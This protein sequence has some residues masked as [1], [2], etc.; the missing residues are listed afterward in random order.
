MFLSDMT[1]PK[2]RDLDRG[3]P[4]VIPIA[5]VESISAGRA[6]QLVVARAA[7][8][9]VITAIAVNLV[10]SVAPEDNIVAQLPCE[11]IIARGA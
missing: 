7:I 2:V 9:P 3:L 6:R 5:A 8:Y 11:G 10:V 4:V 1:W